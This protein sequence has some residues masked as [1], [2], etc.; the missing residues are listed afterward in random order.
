MEKK[1]VK[2]IVTSVTT[3]D[4]EPD[5]NWKAINKIIHSAVFEGE[6]E[7]VTESVDAMS[8]DSSPQSAIQTAMGSTLNYMFETVYN[9]GFKDLIAYREYERKLESDRKTKSIQNS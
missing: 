7:W 2:S 8:I 1:M 9:K 5:G 6:T 3:C 4:L